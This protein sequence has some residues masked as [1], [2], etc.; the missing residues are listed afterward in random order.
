ME[1]SGRGHSLGNT[2]R[3]LESFSSILRRCTTRGLFSYSGTRR[4]WTPH[5]CR[6]QNLCSPC[7]ALRYED[8]RFEVGRN[9]DYPT[10][11]PAGTMPQVQ[12][13]KIMSLDFSRLTVPPSA[14]TFRNS[15]RYTSHRFCEIPHSASGRGQATLSCLQVKAGAIRDIPQSSSIIAT[16][17][18]RSDRWILN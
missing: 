9:A 17:R 5:A 2:D 8:T 13:K 11:T 18:S 7:K 15:S 14:P 6:C 1:S 16:M 10:L 4:R 12:T 3:S